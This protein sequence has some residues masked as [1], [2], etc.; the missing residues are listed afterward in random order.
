M[1]TSPNTAPRARMTAPKCNPI[2]A[3]KG[4][5]DSWWL[6]LADGPQRCLRALEQAEH[7]IALRVDEITAVLGDDRAYRVETIRDLPQGGIV[8]DALIERH[9]AHDISQEDRG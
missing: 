6:D 8:A 9:A 2:R 7:V 5:F 4:S 1:T 3:I